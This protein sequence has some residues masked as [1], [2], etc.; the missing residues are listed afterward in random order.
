MKTLGRTAILLLCYVFPAHSQVMGGCAAPPATFKNVWYIDPV[1]GKTPAAGGNGSQAH[2]WNSLEAITA[3][4]PG[5]PYPLLTTAPYR[6]AKV[7]NPATGA[8]AYVFAPGPKAGPIEPGDEILLMSGNYGNVGICQNNT[9]ISNPSFVTVAAAP[10]QTPVLTSL[11][12]C[13]TNMWAFVGLKVQS[14]E[15]AALSGAALVEVKDQGATY[16]TSNIVFE[17]MT[18]SSQDDA[19]GWTQAQWVT[20]G[21]NGFIAESS[22]GGVNT[23]CISMTGSHITNVRF[24]AELLA[25]LTLFSS[26]EIDHFGDDGIDYGASQLNILKNYVHDNL[27]IGDGNHEDAMQGVIGVPVAGVASNDYAYILI[28]SNTIIRSVDQS[29][30]FPTY[31]QGIDAFDEDW[32]YL[33]V[34]NNVVITSACWGIEFS[35]VHGGLIAD[36]TVVNDGLIAMPGGCQPA[37]SVGDKTHEGSSSNAVSVRNNLANAISVYNLDTGVAADHNVGMATA[38]AVFS[39]YVSG[40]LQYYG[41]PGTYGNANIIAAGGPGNEFVG[42]SPPATY[43]VMIKSGAKAIGAATPT[44]APTVDILG[45]TRGPPYVDVAGA[46]SYPE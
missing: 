21:R 31:L 15:A 35:S 34:T 29:L 40:V 41:S 14:L 19:S 27:N 10:G 20:N 17:N 7:T 24:G 6:Y 45:V 30:P 22:A 5:Y 8:W 26:N 32:T 13:S 11:F 28:D 37:V 23:K 9:E 44:G 3:A 43:N 4:V 42:F 18:I 2:P 38:G 33:T 1:K 16:P 25:N 39:W 36:N 46:Y 12:V